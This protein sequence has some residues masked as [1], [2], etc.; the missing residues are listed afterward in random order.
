MNYLPQRRTDDLLERE[1]AGELVV[2]D[3]TSHQAHC[4]S[5]VAARIWQL[6]DGGTPRRRAIDALA[7]ETSSRDAAEAL[8]D[9][10]LDDLATAGLLADTPGTARDR[11]DQL[12]RRR[13]LV[14]AAAASLVTSI[15][16]PTAAMAQSGSLPNGAA[17]GTSSDCAS[18]CCR[19]GRCKP[20]G[21][22]CS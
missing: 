12:D 16:V 2:Y 5:P 11:L 22:S 4:L 17:C 14:G 1:V 19:Q 9:R 7:R 8:L 6:A 18:N 10:T 15:L 3:P 20:G 13:F 21:G